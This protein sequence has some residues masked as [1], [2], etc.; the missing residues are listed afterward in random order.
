MVFFFCS[1][2]VGASELILVHVYL[3]VA[4]L[5]L[6]EQFLTCTWSLLE[7]IGGELFK[8]ELHESPWSGYWRA[9][10]LLLCGPV[11]Q[12]HSGQCPVA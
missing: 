1:L 8:F 7:L 10:E 5:A 11:C 4:F 9:P 2:L 12:E 6:E 3:C